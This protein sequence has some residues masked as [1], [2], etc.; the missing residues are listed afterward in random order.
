MTFLHGSIY[1]AHRLLAKAAKQQVLRPL[2]TTACQR[3]NPLLQTI[4]NTHSTRSLAVPSPIRPGAHTWHC[5]NWFSSSARRF[6]IWS[7][8]VPPPCSA[9]V[10]RAAPVAALGV[11]TAPALALARYPAAAAAASKL[12]PLLPPAWA[13]CGGGCCLW[14]CSCCGCCCWRCLVDCAMELLHVLE[15]SDAT[16]A[17][18]AWE[19][20]EA[21][22]ISEACEADVLGMVRPKACLVACLGVNEGIREV[23][24]QVAA[25][26]LVASPVATGACRTWQLQHMAVVR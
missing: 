13:C 7:G 17:S 18:D 12:K 9:S 25:F 23:L 22:D 11:P 14:C 10:A 16:E 20:M 19:A 8:L 3:I 15:V 24:P 5:F 2:L 26:L 6:C 4:H 21:S 1:R